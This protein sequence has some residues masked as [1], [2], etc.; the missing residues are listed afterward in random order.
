MYVH[1]ILVKYTSTVLTPYNYDLIN[2]HSMYHAPVNLY[3]SF[4]IWG[5]LLCNITH[6]HCSLKQQE[7]S[8]YKYRSLKLGGTAPQKL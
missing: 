5:V 6:L 4:D 3:M 1:W 2:C 8:E 7:G